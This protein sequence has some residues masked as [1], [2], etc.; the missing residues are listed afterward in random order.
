MVDGRAT[1]RTIADALQAPETI[2]LHLAGELVA[3]NIAI[4][5]G[6]TA[7]NHA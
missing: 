1:L 5:A 6:R 2:I 3:A 7:T 4:I